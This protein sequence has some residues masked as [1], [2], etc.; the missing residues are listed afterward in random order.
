MRRYVV[1]IVML[2]MGY[3]SSAQMKHYYAEGAILGEI[4]YAY[5]YEVMLSGGLLYTYS[6][7]LEL[8]GELNLYHYWDNFDRAT[9]VGICPVIKVNLINFRK[10]KLFVNV[11]GGVIYMNVAYP[12]GGSQ[13]NFTF[14]GGIGYETRISDKTTLYLSTRYAHMSNGE[15]YGVANNPT[16]DALGVVFGFSHTIR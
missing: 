1:L 9:G 5:S 2:L 15:I 16:W 12:Y 14:A 10:S 13:L 8:G 6:K 11:K 4:T 3:D 7:H